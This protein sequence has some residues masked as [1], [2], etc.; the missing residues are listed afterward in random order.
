MVL[1]TS[2]N[3]AKPLF[4]VREINV[5]DFEIAIVAS[6]S[7]H[8]NITL[9]STPKFVLILSGRCVFL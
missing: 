2:T 3:P 1:R 9:G 8:I 4:G 6:P 7:T 5:S